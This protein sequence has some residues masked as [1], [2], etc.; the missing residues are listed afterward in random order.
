MGLYHFPQE[1]IF[2]FLSLYTNRL[3]KE[4][5]KKVQIRGTDNWE[6]PIDFNAKTNKSICKKIIE[7][8]EERCLKTEIRVMFEWKWPISCTQ[9]WCCREA[10]PKTICSRWKKNGWQCCCFSLHNKIRIP[11]GTLSNTHICTAIVLQITL[12]S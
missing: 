12:R 10:Y 1:N 4:D 2:S 9:M 5:K 3:E 8:H 7:V 6:E 11:W